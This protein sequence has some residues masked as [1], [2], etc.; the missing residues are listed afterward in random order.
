MQRQFLS[1]SRGSLNTSVS[2][3]KVSRATGSLQNSAKMTRDADGQTFSFEYRSIALARLDPKFIPAC[4]TLVT[5]LNIHV[6]RSLAEIPSCQVVYRTC[7]V[8]RSSLNLHA[9]EKLELVDNT[10][11]S[12]ETGKA[13]CHRGAVIYQSDFG[14]RGSFKNAF[15]IMEPLQVRSLMIL[16]KHLIWYVGMCISVTGPENS[17]SETGRFRSLPGGFFCISSEKNILWAFDVSGT[18]PFM[19]W[20]QMIVPA[21]PTE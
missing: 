7:H 21:L 18:C 17:L 10:A 8:A 16:F 1:G 14:K 13:D 19:Y 9:L 15:L 2:P 3:S 5:L 6:F 11:P 12:T 20:A 4:Q